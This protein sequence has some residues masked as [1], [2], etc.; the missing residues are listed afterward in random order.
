MQTPEGHVHS[1]G[2]LAEST[3]IEAVLTYQDLDGDGLFETAVCTV[4]VPSGTLTT[5]IVAQFISDDIGTLEKAPDIP[6]R[7][8]VENAENVTL[9][10]DTWNLV[11][12]IKYQ[13]VNSGMLDPNDYP[14]GPGNPKTMAR[15]IQVFRRRTDPTGTT[16]D[17]AQAIFVWESEPYPAFARSYYSFPALQTRDPS[18]MRYVLARGNVRD[19][20][21]G[22]IYLGDGVY[23]EDTQTWSGRVDWG[24][25]RS[26]DRVIVR[27]EA[28]NTDNSW[29][30]VIARL[31]AAELTRPICACT[32][33]NKELA[34]WQWDLSRNGGADEVYSSPQDVTN[35]IGSRRGHVFA[36]RTL[37][38]LQRTIGFIAG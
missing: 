9:T 1:L 2:Y 12:P 14:V 24:A 37:Q 22:I 33:A 26:P 32:T 15:S 8:I 4:A 29:K 17:T 35:P 6:I 20:R 27:Y 7:K 25:Y 19:S 13:G 11:R 10:F 28:G 38:Q 23:D 18:A 36:W 3:P 5:E 30:T 21:S 31:A 34:E 16:L